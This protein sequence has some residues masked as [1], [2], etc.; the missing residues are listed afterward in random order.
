MPSVHFGRAHGVEV[1][2]ISIQ[3]RFS[4]NVPRLE[5]ALCGACTCIKPMHANCMPGS[6]VRAWDVTQHRSG[7]PPPVWV[8][9]ELCFLLDR[10]KLGIRRAS[11]LKLWEVVDDLHHAND[12]CL[13]PT[14][15]AE[16]DRYRKTL[17]KVSVHPTSQW[18]LRGVRDP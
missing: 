16:N 6:A 3:H 10:C 8:S 14:T 7:Q 2:Y 13:P 1:T 11:T 18:K 12:C 15:P 5:C 17:T 9:V 4:V